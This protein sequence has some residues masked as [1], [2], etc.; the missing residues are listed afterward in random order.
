MTFDEKTNKI[1]KYMRDNVVLSRDGVDFVIIS[2][3][4]YED[5]DCVDIKIGNLITN[6]NKFF[7]DQE[8]KFTI[9]RFEL[10]NTNN[11]MTFINK[12]VNGDFDK[13]KKKEKVMTF[14]EKA[15]KIT[16]YM[17]E[18]QILVSSISACDLH[19]KFKVIYCMYHAES[20]MIEFKVKCLNSGRI[21]YFD[22]SDIEFMDSLSSGYYEQKKKKEV[23]IPFGFE[24]YKVGMVLENKLTLRRCMVIEVTTNSIALG[25]SEKLVSSLK[26]VANIWLLLNSNGS[27]SGLYK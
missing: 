16:K 13:E 10:T 11:S 22:S 4:S 27:T 23:K 14:K 2:Y 26:E 25:R 1:T 5:G 9:R 18:G 6:G 7:D 19:K 8:V 15:E 3:R 24:D 12:L 20:E 21:S 17:K